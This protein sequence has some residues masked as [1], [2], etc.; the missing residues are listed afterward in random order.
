LS[1]HDIPLSK[2]ARVEEFAVSVTETFFSGCDADGREGIWE[3]NGTTTV[4]IAQLESQPNEPYVDFTAVNGVVLFSGGGSDGLNGLYVTDGSTGGTYQLAVSGASNVEGLNPSNLV[5]LGG[6]VLFTGIDSTSAYG[7]W[8]SNGTSSGTYEIPGTSG[9]TPSDLTVYNGKVL[10]A[11]DKGGGLWVT[12]GTAAGT[13]EVP[14]TSALHPE[15]MTVYDGKTYFVDDAETPNEG[16][17]YVTDGTQT[18]TKELGYV[19]SILDLTV[20]GTDMLFEAQDSNGVDYDLFETNG[21]TVTEVAGSTGIFDNLQSPDLGFGAL[22]PEITEF[23]SGK[24]VFEGDAANGGLTLWVATQG[25]SGAYT[26]TEI[27]GPDSAAIFPSTGDPDFNA[28]DFAVLNGEVVFDG[29]S[30]GGEAPDFGQTGLWVTNGL[31]SGTHAVSGSTA[32]GY[33]STLGLD[34]S[35]MTTLTLPSQPMVSGIAFSEPDGVGETTYLTGSVTPAAAAAGVTIYNGATELG[36]AT[37][38][39]G[40]LN[41]ALTL[42]PGTYVDILAKTTINGQTVSQA[43]PFDLVIG[44]TGEPYQD[45]L[46]LKDEA[47]AITGQD[48]YQN[49][50]LYLEDTIEQFSNGESEYI[51]QG[52]SYF[53]SVRYVAY[54]DF[55]SYGEFAGSKFFYYNPAG[56]DLPNEY[57]YYTDDLSSN[58]TSYEFDYYYDAQD[59]TGDN[60]TGLEVETTTGGLREKAIYSGVSGAAYS[61]LEED[62]VGGVFAGAIY[63]YTDVP[64]GATYSSYARLFNAANVYTGAE[65]FYS[66]IGGNA[67]ESEQIDVNPKGV[68]TT[69]LLTGVTGRAYTSI[70]YNYTNGVYTSYEAVYNAP[71]GASYKAEQVDATASGTVTAA[72]FYAVAGASYYSVEEDYSGGKLADAIY[73]YDKA[74]V[75]NYY[76]DQV[77]DNAS[78]DQLV[79]TF[80]LNNGGHQI[81]ARASGQT[82]TSLGDDIMTGSATGSTTFVFKSIYGVDTITNLT[83]KDVVDLPSA[84]WASLAGAEAHAQVV[85]GQVQIAAPDGDVL[86]LMGIT[87]LSA[88]DALEGDF[89]LT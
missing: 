22:T 41:F 56:S 70:Q 34:P 33:T 14:G 44:V 87:T 3:Y 60:Y 76:A 57:F 18:G 89:H 27:T 58:G 30:P 50:N 48:F 6:E 35:S 78:R 11:A 5:A 46:D 52:G 38:S 16:D 19:G 29:V 53:E 68:D 49:S 40:N 37:T 69:V 31:A 77:E 36:K 74:P 28:P 13:S 72:I 64:T 2:R 71:S 73:S 24:A 75:G 7:L 67:G 21:V 79:D 63:T 1:H 80:D 85:G 82:L 59:L 9:L 51:Y 55:Y 17:L 39:Y 54:D 88:F 47:G 15:D 23:A 12:N 43:A 66:D 26:L 10:F 62:Y 65:Y 8:V 61:Q 81:T 45:V 86:K 20:V 4:E 25:S 83:N 32:L 42:G 84:D